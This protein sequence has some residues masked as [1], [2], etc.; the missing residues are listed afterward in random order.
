MKSTIRDND[1]VARYGG[2]EFAIILPSTNKEGALILAERLRI[3]IE[4]FQFSQ[5]NIQPNGKLTISIGVAVYPD[6]ALTQEDLIVAADRAL[7]F[8]KESGRNKVIVF[9]EVAV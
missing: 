3:K 6:N 7:Y 4:Q 8:A 9:S 2:E 1:I 5:E